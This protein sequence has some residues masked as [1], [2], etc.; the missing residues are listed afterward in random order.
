MVSRLSGQTSIWGVVFFV[1]KSL[2]RIE[3][4][5][6]FKL[7]LQFDPKASEVYR[8]WPIELPPSP[9]LPSVTNIPFPSRVTLLPYVFSLS[10]SLAAPFPLPPPTSPYLPLLVG[11]SRLCSTAF[12]QLMAFAAFFCGCSNL[13]QF[14]PFWATFGQNILR[15]RAHI[16]HEK[17]NDFVK[18]LQFMPIS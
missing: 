18:K 14:L 6:K 11:L 8:R 16:K 12:E 2:L 1:S 4:Q 7:N 10:V 9:I 3:R 13:K 17:V 5:R 15:F